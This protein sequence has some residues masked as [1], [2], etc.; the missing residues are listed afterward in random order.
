MV[1]LAFLT[2]PRVVARVLDHIGLPSSPPPL[3][4]PRLTSDLSFDFDQNQDDGSGDID[5][6][7]HTAHSQPHESAGH[8]ARPPP[9]SANA[10]TQDGL[11][12]PDECSWPDECNRH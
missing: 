8:D 2:D 4:P 6:D 12:W 10:P 3:T 5:P 7:R 11:A 1:V 9:G